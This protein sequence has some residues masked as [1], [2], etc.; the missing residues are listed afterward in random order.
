MVL[1]LKYRRDLV[2]KHGSLLGNR[3]TQYREKACKVNEQYMLDN[4]ETYKN[5][6][7]IT[8]KFLQNVRIII[9]NQKNTN[10]LIISM[11]FYYF[12]L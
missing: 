8:L 7:T 4:V 6:L 3:K 12:L 10:T 2:K 11:H 1:K 5:M 9:Y